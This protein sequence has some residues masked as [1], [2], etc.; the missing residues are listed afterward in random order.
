MERH[1]W[2]VTDDDEYDL[3]GIEKGSPKPWE[4]G[5]RTNGAKGTYEWWY[6]DSKLNDGSSLVVVF[7]TKHIASLDNNYVP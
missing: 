3:L 2:L 1:A 6:F 5:L 4:D 7:F